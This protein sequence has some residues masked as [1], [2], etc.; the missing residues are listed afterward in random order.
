[1]GPIAR[2][3]AIIEAAR[4]EQATSLNLSSLGLT[5]EDLA[6][7]CPQ[8]V[9]L[10]DL[11]KL[12]LSNNHLTT[13]PEAVGELTALTELNL[14]E[15]QL[16]TLPEAVGKLTALTTLSLYINHL[17]AFPK[18]I[19]SLSTLTTLILAGNQLATL[20]ETVGNLTALTTLELTS[21]QLTSL[22]EAVGN[23]TTITTLSLYSNQLACLPSSIG[24]LRKLQK[25]GVSHGNRIRHIP[26]ELWELTELREIG[27]S[28]NGIT[29]LSS[30]IE[31]LRDLKLL[32][33]DDNQLSKLP[34]AL[35]G[36]ERLEALFLHGNDALGLPAEVLGP[37]WKESADGKLAARPADI[38][39]FYFESQAAK[40]TGTLNPIHE[41]KVMLV[42]RGG[43]GKTSLR[44]F[45]LGQTH[46]P[47]EP[48]TPGIALD[49]F[50]TL[51]NQEQITVHLWDFAGQEITHA[52]H[53]FFLTQ[54]SIY[55]LVLDPRSNTEMADAF[56]WLDQLRRFAPGAPVL[57]ALN[58]QDARQ[59]GYDVGR[60][61]LMERYPQVIKN[62]VK[63]NCS[64]RDGC[65][66]L[67]VA[68]TKIIAE[69]SP[70]ELPWMAV[71]DSWLGVKGACEEMRKPA[72]GAGTHATPGA[73]RTTVLK[74]K[75]TF[76]EFKDLCTAKGITDTDKQESLARILHKLGA[77]L[78]F[79][80][81]P[82]LR[83]T[84]VLNPH[85]VTDGVYRLLRAKDRPKSDGTLTLEEAAGVLEDKSKDSAAFLLRLMERF[86]MCY[87]LDEETPD[88]DRWL[89]P[90]ALD[91]YQPEGLG[92]KWKGPGAVRMRYDY[93]S[94]AA[95][96][97][98]PR[99][100]VLTHPL[101][102]EAVWRNGV[103]LR[104]G[105]AAALVRR[106]E[107]L[108]YIEVAAFGPEGPR[109]R[110]LEV[111][112]GAMARI[113]AD[114][115]GTQP[116]IEKELEWLPGGIGGVYR[117]IADLRAAEMA[118]IPIVVGSTPPPV[119]VPATPQLDSVS[120]LASRQRTKTPLKA[121]LSY[122][123]KDRAAKNVFVENL[124]V[125]QS[126]GLIQSSWHDGMIEPG[127]EWK[128]AIEDQLESMDLFIGLVTTPFLAS[129]FIQNV[130]LTAARNR[131][132]QRGK[133]DFLF[134]LILVDDLS[135]KGLDL[136]QYQMIIPAEKP[137]CKHTSRRNGFNE[138]Q[139]K[140][141]ELVL[142]HMEREG[143]DGMGKPVPATPPLT[144]SGGSTGI[145]IIV[146][147][148]FVEGG[149]H[150][151]NDNRIKIGGHAINS[152][153]GQTLTNCTN[154]V[155]Q[156]AP[157]KKKDAMDALRRD[158]E[159]LI[160]QLPT[161]KMDKA[162]KVAK[163]LETTIQQAAEAEPDREWYSLSAKGLLEAATWVKDFSGKIGGT[164]KNLGTII[165]PDFTLPLLPK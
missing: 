78:H 150:M 123:H 28:G 152:Q 27:F 129:S 45:F 24:S 136:A 94:P 95:E 72:R 104:D 89:L 22:P 73:A 132:K 107:K 97:I 61:L 113:N 149:K 133:R 59:G 43:A 35:R 77:V 71:P 143:P 66:D 81:D 25:L 121:F 58:R 122:S 36:L 6:R 79:V 40:A 93:G 34:R 55:I 54:G 48:E 80:D 64:T 69:Q 46:D 42:G 75:L 23:L 130:E 47:K 114:L 50:T 44:R 87:P 131:L 18:V 99:F 148:D 17:A 67:L 159:E 103:V 128:K 145:T 57:V 158:V 20:P 141:E 86:E 101:K 85:W 135:L 147:G 109:L 3:R 12:D 137:I 112:Q 37:S 138:A 153:V 68:L 105:E 39:N 29:E 162:S 63:T 51:C 161:D 139:R 9:T 21:N 60:D 165:W 16:K 33:L 26:D 127:I 116:V 160:K 65:T 8:I 125:M 163:N 52:L 119:R 118:E 155:N 117:S 2:A 142:R 82:R 62:F 134:A 13:L 100:I 124:S 98:I 92:E 164:I 84:S 53:Q 151:G 74:P 106:G 41:I 56:Y 10:T 110:L 120:E 19:G 7:L 38:L 5:T 70:L 157:G 88:A 154:M 90:G 111:V 15:N 31:S 83:D 102:G 140:L 14:S 146:E 32:F 11:T 108:N 126:K 156:Q 1:M 76:S 91:P 96:G 144:P 30:R 4:D 49:K 115:P